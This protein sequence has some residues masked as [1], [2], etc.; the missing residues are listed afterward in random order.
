MLLGGVATVARAAAGRHAGRS[1][2]ALSAWTGTVAKLLLPRHERRKGAPRWLAK[3]LRGR[4]KLFGRRS[5]ATRGA[6]GLP[7]D[8]R[9]V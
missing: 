7:R 1:Q 9:G 8:G 6:T 4:S 3:P 2:V 5:R